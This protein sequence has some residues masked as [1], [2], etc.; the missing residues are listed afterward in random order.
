[1][2]LQARRTMTIQNEAPQFPYPMTN[3]Q[4]EKLAGRTVIASTS[5]G[6]DSTAMT[7]WLLENGIKPICV[8]IDVGWEA[9]WTYEYVRNVLPKY[10]GEITWLK[11]EMQMEERILHKGMF[12]SRVRRWCTPELKAVPFGKYVATLLDQGMEVVNATGI[13]WKESKA[14]AKYSEWE[15]SDAYDCDTWRPILPW[16]EQDVI[17]MMNK[18]GIPPNPLYMKGATR[19]GCWPCIFQKKSEIN[20]MARIDPSRIDYLRELEKKVAQV[21]DEKFGR[22]G[23]PM[24]WFVAKDGSEGGWPIDKAVAWATKHGQE[25]LF[26]DPTPGCMRWGLCETVTPEGDQRQKDENDE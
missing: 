18:Y 20:L 17:D 5:G 24:S 16:S 25:E 11:P 23:T 13:R 2:Y 1:M 22:G 14:R 21:G 3:A 4:R 19:V 12:P 26:T 15:W 6:K 10:F 8:F 7:L 9:K